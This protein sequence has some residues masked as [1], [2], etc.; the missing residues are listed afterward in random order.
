MGETA[1]QGDELLGLRRK[2]AQ[3]ESQLQAAGAGIFQLKQKALIYQSLK[4]VRQQKALPMTLLK[5]N[6]DLRFSLSQ[7]LDDRS[8]LVAELSD[9]NSDWFGN[10]D[11]WAH[12]DR[13]P[14]IDV[15]CSRTQGE[16][17]LV[18]RGRWSD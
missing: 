6:C 12:W 8:S 3:L 7:V 1:A 14:Q 18:V 15:D 17:G 9:I 13:R 5:K 11:M 2:V 4:E 16:S 10:F